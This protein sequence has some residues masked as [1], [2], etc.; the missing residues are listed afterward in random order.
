[1]HFIIYCAIYLL[2]AA[3]GFALLFA[4]GAAVIWWQDR[5]KRRE[6]TY[7]NSTYRP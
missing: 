1:M 2:E 3:F 5:H 4:T 7:F 6:R